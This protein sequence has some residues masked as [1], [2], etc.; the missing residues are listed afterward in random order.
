MNDD[1]ALKTVYEMYAAAVRRGRTV[2]W[3]SL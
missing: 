3:A 2:P 1:T